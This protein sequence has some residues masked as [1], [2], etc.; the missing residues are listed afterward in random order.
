[1][2]IQVNLNGR[3]ILWINENYWNTELKGASEE[4]SFKLRLAAVQQALLHLLL[5]SS[6]ANWAALAFPFDQKKQQN[7]KARFIGKTDGQVMLKSISSI[8]QH[9]Y[10]QLDLKTRQ[11]LSPEIQKQIIAITNP[12][13]APIHWPQQ[14]RAFANNSRRTRLKTSRRRPSQ[15][16]AGSPGLQIQNQQKLL[17]AI[18][19]SGSITTSVLQQFFQTIH[20]VWRS[21]ATLKIVECDDRIR[22]QYV[23]KGQAPTL[24]K[25]RG[26]TLFDPPIRFANEQYLP[27]GLIY[28][29]DGEGRVPQLKCCC[30][31]LW[32]ISP[33]GIKKGSY[34]WKQLT[35]RKLKMN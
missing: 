1:M 23:Y 28:F 8:F 30:P 13:V 24:V 18:D 19:T 6:A 2:Q 16:Y 32:I 34:E 4:T 11:A 25:G 22:A 27:D 7:N 10:T 35:G 17:L 12:I 21:G 14:L 26:A 15:R 5:Y 31:I 9:S 29:T 3:I 20:Q 33:D